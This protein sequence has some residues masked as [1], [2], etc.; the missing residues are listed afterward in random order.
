M[1]SKLVTLCGCEKW[2]EVDP[3]AE[4][5]MVPYRFSSKNYLTFAPDSLTF[6]D[7]ETIL[8]RRF[9]YQMGYSDLEGE[10]N[11]YREVYEGPK[12][13]KPKGSLEDITLQLENLV[14]E[15]KRKTK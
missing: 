8:T 6:P 15:I 10:Y 12:A 14:E 11:E 2:I 5:V 3:N 13:S 4:F 1:R 7:N 9:D